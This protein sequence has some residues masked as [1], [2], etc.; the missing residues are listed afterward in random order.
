MYSGK[1]DS[2]PVKG[3]S[4]NPCP[5]ND[6]CVIISSDDEENEEATNKQIQDK[7]DQQKKIFL[8]SCLE[9]ESSDEARQNECETMPNQISIVKNDPDFTNLLASPNTPV[10]FNHQSSYSSSEL[11]FHFGINENQQLISTP[12][13]SEI[14]QNA[15]Y[16]SNSDYIPMSP[17]LIYSQSQPSSSSIQ[18][19]FNDFDQET[20][21]N[22]YEAMQNQTI[23]QSNEGNNSSVFGVSHSSSGTSTD[24]NDL[25]FQGFQASST[26]NQFL[27]KNVETN[28]SSNHMHGNQGSADRLGTPSQDEDKHVIALWKLQEQIE[29]LTGKVDQLQGQTKEQNKST[30]H[31]DSRNKEHRKHRD[32][33]S[34]EKSTTYKERGRSRSRSYNRKHRSRSKDRYYRNRDRDES[35]HRSHRRRSDSRSKDARSKKR[36]NSRD[37]FNNSDRSYSRGKDDRFKKQSHS[38]DNVDNKRRSHSRDR[39]DSKKRSSLQNDKIYKQQNDAKNQKTSETMNRTYQ[40]TQPSTSVFAS[41]STPS[42]SN[43][44]SAIKV[45]YQN[46]ER[47][48]TLHKGNLFNIFLKKKQIFLIS[49]V[50]EYKINFTLISYF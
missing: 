39:I 13:Q 33:D 15:L 24:G 19:N 20:T 35:N 29:Q 21:Q 28:A 38:Y 23:H 47:N 48:Q 43:S 37:R 46:S 25:A 17:N 36:S 45:V 40:F 22:R 49:I 3:S 12:N 50:K 31:D 9:D 10:D 26:N 5:E 8:E 34:R 2:N 44:S 4:G 11:P 16:Q 27:F 42:C 41:T 1:K 30:L 18:S 32:R 14:M 6:I 7:C